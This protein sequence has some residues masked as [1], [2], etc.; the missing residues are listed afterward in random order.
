MN[1]NQY[2]IVSDF[3]GTITCEDS[4]DLLFHLCGNAQNARI[5]KDFRSGALSTRIAMVQHFDIMHITLETYHSFLKANIRIDPGFDEFLNQVRKQDIDFFVVSAG[6]R[7]AIQHVL[8]E[9][10][11]R[12]VQ[13]FANDLRGE[14]HLKP[15]FAHDGSVCTE[16]ATGPCGSCK[17]DCIET[18]RRQT[19]QSI[20]YI[21]DGLTDRCAVQKADLIFAKNDLARYCHANGLPYLPF[22]S[23]AD[24]TRYISEETI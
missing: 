10:R 16:R 1:R 3:D 23:F 6:Y 13:I 12:G 5:E 20:I 24:I 19:N 18:I 21:G 8:G 22:E 14:E 2:A 4:N 15:F 11:L 17:K 9:K 7:Q